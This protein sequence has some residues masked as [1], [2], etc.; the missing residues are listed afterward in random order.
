MTGHS[1]LE[2]Y[3]D[4]W[5]TSMGG[6]FPGEKVILRG[7][8]VFTELND[9]TWM[10]YLLFA[11]T[12]RESAKIA[13][14][15]EGMWVICTSFP[16]PRIWNNR[17]SALAGTARSTGALA[18]AASVAVTEATLYGLKPIKG[19]SEF[20]YR[21]KDTCPDKDNLEHF[22]KLELKKHRSIFGYGRPLL[23][24]DERVE[25]MLNFAQSIGCGDGEF[26]DLVF[27][28]EDILMNSRLRYRVNIAAVCA[29]L[30]ADVGMAPMDFYNMMILGFSA[31]AVPCYIDA[32]KQREG[33]FFPLRTSRLNYIG[34]EKD[35]HWRV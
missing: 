15:M 2:K 3:E 27:Q 8:N 35:R 17:V 20:L 10:E 4:N 30:L 23:N 25:P 5:Q 12:G 9:R 31:G 6:W 16:D 28:V 13:K 34:A 29:G 7:K 1:K 26:V 21:A 33:C 18:A 14:L 24:G 19:A 32:S 22:V 11:A